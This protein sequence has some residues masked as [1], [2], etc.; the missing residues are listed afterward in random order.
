[1]KFRLHQ[2]ATEFEEAARFNASIVAEARLAAE[3]KQTPTGDHPKTVFVVVKDN[4][5]TEV[6]K[7]E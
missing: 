7:P 5:P 3:A 6:I 2:Y 4:E 1:V